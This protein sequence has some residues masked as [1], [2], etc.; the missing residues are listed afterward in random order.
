MFGGELGETMAKHKNI[1]QY[2]LGTVALCV[3]K[4]YHIVTLGCIWKISGYICGLGFV[5]LKGI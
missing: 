3:C 2:G 4:K 5:Y 1:T